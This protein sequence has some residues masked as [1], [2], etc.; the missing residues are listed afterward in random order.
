LAALTPLPKAL[1]IT[2]GETKHLS[3]EE[4]RPVNRFAFGGLALATGAL[5]V[6]FIK[7]DLL[8]PGS[9]AV[10]LDGHGNATTQQQG[11]A[12]NHPD[13][14]TKIQVHVEGPAALKDAPIQLGCTDCTPAELASLNP[15][16]LPT[17]NHAGKNGNYTEAT[18][19]VMSVHTYT[20]TIMLGGK[21][22][23]TGAHITATQ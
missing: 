5:V 19:Y 18:T 7:P 6:V 4:V 23:D 3:T 20:V 12:L 16:P 21:P 11:V 15:T 14:R 1:I 9:T 8:P 22:H 2:T 10:T 17:L 13:P